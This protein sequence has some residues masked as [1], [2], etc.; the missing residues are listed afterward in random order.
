M[1]TPN[2][3][4][5][6]ARATDGVAAIQLDGEGLAEQEIDLVRCS[7]PPDSRLVRVERGWEP[8]PGIFAV[9]EDNHCSP[10]RKDD[11]TV[12]TFE[13]PTTQRE[14]QRTRGLTVGR[15]RWR[16]TLRKDR[17]TPS[18]EFRVGLLVGEVF[19]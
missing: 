5:F 16:V 11:L 4:H 1:H 19:P 7:L 8:E 10:I 9:A 2:R 3:W 18:M 12:L 6:D 13:S 17:I 15:V 14:A